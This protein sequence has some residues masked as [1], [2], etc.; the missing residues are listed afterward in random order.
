MDSSEDV[1]SSIWNKYSGWGCT[2]RRSKDMGVLF[3][4]GSSS[5]GT[6]KHYQAL[7]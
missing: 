5:L 3:E 1:A 2:Q 6:I 4:D 7:E